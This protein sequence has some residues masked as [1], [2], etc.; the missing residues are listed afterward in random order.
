[1]E[2]QF[3][4][5]QQRLLKKFEKEEDRR[6]D[7]AK[8]SGSIVED[9]KRDEDLEARPHSNSINEPLLNNNIGN[10]AGLPLN[11]NINGVVRP[12]RVFLWVYQQP[13]GT[14]RICWLRNLT[15]EFIIMLMLVMILIM[16]IILF[17]IFTR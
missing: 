9:Y 16:I 10:R 12:R 2:T 11:P 3:S 5:R 14:F 1:M 13:N 8:R 6:W 4:K 15:K 17:V 7:E